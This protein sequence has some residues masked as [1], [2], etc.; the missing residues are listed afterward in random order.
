MFPLISDNILD[1]EI[2]H[3]TGLFISSDK[4]FMELRN[5][6]TTGRTNINS[7]EIFPNPVRENYYASSL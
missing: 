7:V 4:S 2:N 5:D 1:L 3:N 6:A